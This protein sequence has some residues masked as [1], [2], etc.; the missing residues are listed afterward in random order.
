MKNLLESLPARADGGL[1]NIVVDTPKGSR[2]KFK[3]DSEA[4][5]FRLSRIL[6]AGAIF[7]HDFGAIPRT[8]GEDG[9]ALDVLVIGDAP[10]FAGCLLTGQLI[11]VLSG[12][13]TE[14]GRTIRNDRLLAVPV[15]P[16]NPPS[17]GAI[18]D[19]PESLLGELEHFF[20]SYNA[21]QGRAYNIIGR[22]GARAA[23]EALAQAERNYLNRRKD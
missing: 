4:G 22:G 19:L 17:Y 2:S 5:C 16:A 12:E 7:P 9:D 6:P 21:A 18:D 3:F 1:V 14:K 23:D 11:G 13:Q 15:T 8:L 10:S 20:K